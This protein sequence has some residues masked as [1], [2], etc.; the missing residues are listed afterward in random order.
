MWSTA[1]IGMPAQPSVEVRE[2]LRGAH[3]GPFTA[4]V[5]A[6]DRTGAQASWASGTEIPWRGIAC[7]IVRTWSEQI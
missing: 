5:G 2:A 6:G 1:G 3:V 4:M 7:S